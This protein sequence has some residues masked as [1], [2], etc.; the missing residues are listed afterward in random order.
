VH[1]GEYYKNGGQGAAVEKSE[2]EA[3]N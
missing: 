2:N 3:V 1:G